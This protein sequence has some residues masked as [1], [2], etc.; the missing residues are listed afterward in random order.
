M[1]MRVRPMSGVDE[2]EN[3]TEI[4][5]FG[6]KFTFLRLLTRIKAYTLTQKYI[7]IKMQ[8]TRKPQKI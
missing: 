6:H 2:F 7:H 4:F 8:L 5:F 3:L 1:K